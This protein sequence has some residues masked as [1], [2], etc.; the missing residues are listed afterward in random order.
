MM[1]ALAQFDGKIEIHRAPGAQEDRRPLRRKA[2]PV[3]GDRHVG[4]EP[5]L[6][7]PA[8]FAQP[9]RA[10]LFAGLDQ[11]HRVEAEPPARR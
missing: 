8:H 3:R 11:Q 6:V 1:P 10:D 2:R 9:G 4:G 7:L 5:V